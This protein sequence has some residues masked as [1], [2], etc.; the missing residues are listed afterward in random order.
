MGVLPHCLCGAV[1][2]C[3]VQRLPRQSVTGWIITQARTA[4]NGRIQA[5]KKVILQQADTGL[6]GQ[7]S[8]TYRQADK[9]ELGTGTR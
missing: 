8:V 9:E 1:Q 2:F 7:H 6:G 4:L 5:G 3:T